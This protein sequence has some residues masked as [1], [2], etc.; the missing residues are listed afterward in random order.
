MKQFRII[1]LGA[2][3]ALLSLGSADAA[4]DNS[5]L[6][7]LQ[8]AT[9]TSTAGAQATITLAA[10]VS[11]QYHAC[12]LTA[13]IVGDASGVSGTHTATLWDG[14][15]TTGINKVNQPLTTPASSTTGWIGEGDWEGSTGTPMTFQFD[16]G[17]SNS[18]IESVTIQYRIGQPC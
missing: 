16:A 10:V 4:F 6:A 3:I 11:Q 14:A 12:R 15:V 17:G 18:A 5:N 13:S 2:L 1:L 9:N 8:T 7:G